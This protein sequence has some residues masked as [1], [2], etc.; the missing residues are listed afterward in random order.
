M[1]TNDSI[2]PKT[3]TLHSR[4]KH[5]MPLTLG[6]EQSVMLYKRY[7]TRADNALYMSTKV[8]RF[9]RRS[10]EAQKNASLIDALILQFLSEIENTTSTLNQ[11]YL[12][13]RPAGSDSFAY[14]N[15]VQFQAACSTHHSV[16]LLNVYEKLDNL[17]GL[18]DALEI[19][20]QLPPD[21]AGKLVDSW[22]HRFRQFCSQINEIRTQSFPSKKT[23]KAE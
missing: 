12:S 23:K 5:N 19:I 13:S 18:C 20:G 8:L 9:Q 7:F 22:V 16:K 4:L 1:Q 14:E 15:N 17:M 3:N 10:E 11:A 6:S 2:E 21:S